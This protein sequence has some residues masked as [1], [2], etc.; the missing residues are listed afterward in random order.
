MKRTHT[1]T[2]T[3]DKK[4]FCLPA[5]CGLIFLSSSHARADHY[6][7]DP[8]QG[9]TGSFYLAQQHIVPYSNETFGY[10]FAIG[11]SGYFPNKI[12]CQGEIS[13]NFRW[14]R[15][16]IPDPFDLLNPFHMIDD[17]TDLPPHT[18]FLSEWCQALW[19][20]TGVPAFYGSCW[21]GLQTMTVQNEMN[22]GKQVLYA[23]QI[24]NAPVP[25][26]D[27]QGNLNYYMTT[28]ISES[29]R[30]KTLRGDQIIPVKCSPYAHAGK[31][32]T[33]DT[34]GYASVYYTADLY[35]I[36][37]RISGPGAIA[38]KKYSGTNGP[39]IYFTAEIKGTTGLLEMTCYIDNTIV[40]HY[41]NPNQYPAEAPGGVNAPPTRIASRAIT[42]WDTTH[43]PDGAIVTLR[44]EAK[45]QIPN[46]PV[47]T[48]TDS[49]PVRV[50]NKGYVME[51]LDFPGHVAVVNPALSAMNHAVLG[52][53][54][55]SKPMILDAITPCTVF[56]VATH[57]NT[58]GF[59]DYFHNT[60]NGAQ[61]V[62]CNLGYTENRTE[63]DVYP[64][65]NAKLAGKIPEYNFVE[66]NSCSGAGGDPNYRDTEIPRSSILT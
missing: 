21:D 39:N 11:P 30:V 2:F 38:N 56:S 66:M 5:I 50:Y 49:V 23:P 20:N 42:A 15:R 8:M 32:A 19:I 55:Q 9:G 43:W 22:G 60:H 26:Y 63:G 58:V 40:A 31:V 13:T 62:D 17:P 48:E 24:Q 41:P 45:F 7:K 51:N 25:F 35:P 33:R 53:L 6:E 57:G 4:M 52:G 36:F 27:P 16:Q 44:M 64:K 65:V 18:V 14:V 47:V 37:A 29:T 46:G 1:S 28:G 3:L 10:G 59:D 12:D 34:Y 61:F 54:N